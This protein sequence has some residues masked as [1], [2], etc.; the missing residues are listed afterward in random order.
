MN[1]NMKTYVRY[2][3]LKIN[4]LKDK[5]YIYIIVQFTMKAVIKTG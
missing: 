1:M 2:T 5:K 3:Y 4:I